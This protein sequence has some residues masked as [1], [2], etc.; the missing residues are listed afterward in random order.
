MLDLPKCADRSQISQQPDARTLERSRLPE[1]LPLPNM[2]RR[3]PGPATG[4]TRGPAT[5][6]AQKTIRAAQSRGREFVL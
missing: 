4:P 6:E 3:R 5:A 2:Q 1:R